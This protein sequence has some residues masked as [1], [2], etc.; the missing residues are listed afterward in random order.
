[1][2]ML[3]RLLPALAAVT[4]AACA[5]AVSVTPPLT[6]V[7]G[8]TTGAASTRPIGLGLPGGARL[9]EGVRFAGGVELVLDATSPLHSL[10]DL[11][12]TGD[13]QGDG[14]F[15]SVTDA[16]DLVR[17]RLVLDARGRLTG[18]SGLRYRRLT[19]LD[20]APIVEKV[21]GD[22]EGLLVTDG[23]D[24]FI[25]FE[26]NHRIWDY[27]SVDAPR[28]VPTP[29]RR[30]D[31]T[32]PL[33]DGMEGIS[34]GHG[35]GWRVTAEN[36]GVWDCRPEACRVVT[37]PPATPPA[38]SDYRTTGMDRAPS[39]DGFFVVQRSYS[40][41][42][43][44]RAQVR[45]MAANGALGPVLIELKLPGTTDNFEGIAAV[46]R[47]GGTRL[48]ILSDDNS[49]PAQRTLLLAFDVRN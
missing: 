22:A 4:L 26:R 11:K 7:T 17:G 46:A 2:T 34:A 10:S 44:A 12:L 9:A 48:Y 29:V 36:G 30:P 31:V 45:R 3:R 6:P 40:P 8:W 23:G 27:G 28:A 37:A 43:D 42:I 16:G 19:L 1:M 38:D 49:N 41:P 25:S 20:G 33:N 39:G 32:L 14:G 24:L 13:A 18:V 21:D 15:V 5:G 35:G 47:D